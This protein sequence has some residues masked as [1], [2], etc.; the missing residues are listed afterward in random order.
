MPASRPDVLPPIDVGAWVRASSVFQSATDPKSLGDW[1]MDSSYIELH[2]GGKIHKNVGLTLNLNANLLAGKAGIEDAIIQLDF[3]DQFHLWA[4]QLLVPVDRSNA[5]GPFFMIPWNFPGFLTVGNTTVVAAP[6]EGP[7][8]RNTG[9]VVWGDISQFKYMLGVFVN[10]NVNTSPLYSGRVSYAFIGKEPGFWGNASYFGDQDVLALI[11]GGQFQKNGASFVDAAMVNHQANYGDFNLDLLA[12]F[13]TG[14][15]WVTGEG[16]YYHF[17]VSDANP[18]AVKD[19][20]FLLGAYASPVVG[21]G[22]IQPMVRYQWANTVGLPGAETT[23]AWNLDIGVAYLIKGP[24]LR[25]IATYGHTSI[26][27]MTGSPITANA[28]QLSAQGIFF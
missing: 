17:A 16:A 9:A 6:A 11:V 21:Y 19:T 23:K 24:A 7:S 12:E 5:A 22:N 18:T 4:G 26:P 27:D 28:V 14:G 20:F 15:G 3:M 1:H 8:G 2:A 10:G 13:K 25:L